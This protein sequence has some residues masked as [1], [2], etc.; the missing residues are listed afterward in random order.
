MQN[1]KIDVRQ[2]N[3]V[4]SLKCGK[5]NLGITND[6]ERKV[7]I[8]FMVHYSR[9]RIQRMVQYSGYYMFA[10]V[11]EKINILLSVVFFFG[12]G[13]G[14]VLHFFGPFYDFNLNTTDALVTNDVP[15]GLPK[16]LLY[17]CFINRHVQT[18]SLYRNNT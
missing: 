15:P 10:Y 1:L 17:S 7:S 4:L 2:E 6:D 5:H 12:G 13:G 8:W 11:Y 14:G 16:V 9:F 18:F 3:G